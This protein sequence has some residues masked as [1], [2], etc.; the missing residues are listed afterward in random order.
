MYMCV[1]HTF[2]VALFFF[3]RFKEEQHNTVTF[4]LWNAHKKGNSLTSQS[5]CNITNK[6]ESIKCEDL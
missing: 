2:L 4:L 6:T 5:D 3:Y 1:N